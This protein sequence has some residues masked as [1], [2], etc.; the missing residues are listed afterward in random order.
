MTPH[1]PQRWGLNGPPIYIHTHTAPFSVP[2]WP[3]FGAIA[4]GEPTSNLGAARAGIGPPIAVG[5]ACPTPGDH[6]G[7][8]TPCPHFSREHAL[9]M[10]EYHNAIRGLPALGQ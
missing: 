6:T 1:G 10:R 4:D 8:G 7:L 2:V 5:A 9:T 3:H